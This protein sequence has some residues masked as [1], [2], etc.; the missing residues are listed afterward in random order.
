MSSQFS[1]D[2]N[3]T[4]ARWWS[5]VGLNNLRGLSQPEWF[6]AFVKKESWDELEEND[7]IQEW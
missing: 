6:C 5:K 3:S 4:K 7:R 1:Q 2:V